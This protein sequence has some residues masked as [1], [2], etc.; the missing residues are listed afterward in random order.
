[1]PNRLT[2]ITPIHRPTCVIGF[3]D[4]YRRLS[5]KP[6]RNKNDPMFSIDIIENSSNLQK[7]SFTIFLER[8]KAESKFLV[9]KK[10]PGYQK[11]IYKLKSKNPNIIRRNVM[12]HNIIAGMKKSSFPSN[13]GKMINPEGIDMIPIHTA[14]I[15]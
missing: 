15:K 4:L 1:M 13:N 10:I 14:K 9:V 11:V 6:I 8:L 7:L 12:S 5:P 2:I 3:W